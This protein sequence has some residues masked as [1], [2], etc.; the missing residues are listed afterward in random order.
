MTTSA[1]F[2]R[3]TV[4]AL[5]TILLAGACS[6]GGD[7]AGDGPSTDGELRAVELY[8]QAAAGTGFDDLGTGDRE[9]VT[10]VGTG[11]GVFVEAVL[12]FDGVSEP[13]R[14]EGE[15]TRLVDGEPFDTTDFSEGVLA[16]DRV[17]LALPLVGVTPETATGTMTVIYEGVLVSTV[18]DD[19]FDF[20]LE[21]D[22]EIR[23]GDLLDLD[24][25]GGEGGGADG[26]GGGL[27]PI[28]VTA[29]GGTVTIEFDGPP[30]TVTAIATLPE[31]FNPEPNE[32]A[33]EPGTLWSLNGPDLVVISID[34][35]DRADV[36]G[37]FAAAVV[38]THGPVEHEDE[39]LGADE[40]SVSGY[41]AVRVSVDRDD[42]RNEAFV[43]DIG[44]FW[45]EMVWNSFADEWDAAE[46]PFETV[47]GSLAIAPAV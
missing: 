31:G 44:G 24:G 17:E 36:S 40:T 18:S 13:A 42:F 1:W 30:G 23:E 41:E 37:N 3:L 34:V 16:D 45:L 22:L 26:A 2:R 35:R 21:G 9:R 47:T 4:S 15:R 39:L 32:F 12:V 46:D 8:F 7:E 10:E 19:E 11:D 28:S 14:A 38:D 6:G 29:E 27:V 33:D 5:A 25:D 20:R 43:V